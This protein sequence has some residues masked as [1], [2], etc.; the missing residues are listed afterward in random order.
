MRSNLTL[1]LRQSTTEHHL[2]GADFIIEYEEYV[3]AIYYNDH[4]HKNRYHLIIVLIGKGT[5]IFTHEMRKEKK[6]VLFK[7]ISLH[8]TIQ[9]RIIYIPSHVISSS[10]FL[11]QGI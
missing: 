6:M 3:K 7:P 11:T 2:A 1:A 9:Q 8:H 10:A 4:P 5:K